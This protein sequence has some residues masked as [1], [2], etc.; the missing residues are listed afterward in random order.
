MRIVPLILIVCSSLSAADS[1]AVLQV[2][3]ATPGLTVY[4]ADRNVGMTPLQAEFPPGE[5]HVRVATPFAQE[6]GQ[7]DFQTVVTLRNNEKT[8]VQ[9]VFPR[10]I[11]IR[12]SP[13]DAAVYRNKELLG[14][15]PL[16]ICV[17][18]D[19]GDVIRLEKEGYVTASKPV[20]EIV[21]NFW[22]VTLAAKES[23][24]QEKSAASLH[25]TQEIKKHRRLMFASLG[26]AALTGLAT[27]HFRDRG[28]D[29]YDRYMTSAIPAEMDRHF[30]QSQKNDRIAGATYALF[31][32]AFVLT[33]YHFLATLPQ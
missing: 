11:V 8:N 20:Q 22:F 25:N 31:E 15:T 28:N 7:V 16:S 26:L 21:D 17:T 33:G 24:L 30:K 5:Y 9:A 27:V 1:L 2:T 10:R 12:S 19:H 4:V 6:W 3:S 23:W 18:T 14:C 13:Y 32:I 29:A